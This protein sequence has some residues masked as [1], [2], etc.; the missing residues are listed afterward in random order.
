[1]AAAPST[2]DDYLAGFP[3]DVRVILERVRAAIR[4]A[5]P[6]AEEKISYQ[7]PTM[8]LDGRS[9]VHF[10]G[11]KHHIAVYPAPDRTGDEQFERRLAPYRGDKGTVRFALREPIPYDLV[12]QIATQ[13][14]EQRR[15]AR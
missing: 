2:V 3:S 14:V 6:G 8:T 15:R 5:V 1:M 7:I 13:L 12:A 10:A 4:D 9:L 11:W